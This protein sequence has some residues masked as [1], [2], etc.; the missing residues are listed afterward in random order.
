[1]S[2]TKNFD[3]ASKLKANVDDIKTF[4]IVIDISVKERTHVCWTV[5]ITYEISSFPLPTIRCQ[6]AWSNATYNCSFYR[7]WMSAL[8]GP[9]RWDLIC[10]AR[11]ISLLSAA[12]AS[13]PGQ[14]LQAGN[15]APFAVYQ[16]PQGAAHKTAHIAPLEQIIVDTHRHNPTKYDQKTNAQSLKYYNQFI[17]KWQKVRRQEKKVFC[18][19]NGGCV[20]QFMAG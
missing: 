17:R 1:M 20:A 5:E 15:A 11:L 4:I 10:V 7:W 13:P 16:T 12:V 8:L 2:T 6:H 14:S 18:E 9:P 19:Y 3:R